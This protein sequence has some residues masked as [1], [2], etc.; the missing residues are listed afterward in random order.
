[1]RLIDLDPLFVQHSPRVEP[2]TIRGAEGVDREEV[3]EVLYR[4]PVEKLADAHGIYFDCPKCVGERGHRVLCWFE[5]R[6]PDGL[7]PGPGRW[8]PE[9]SGFADLSFVPGKKSNSVQLRGG[10]HW[11]GFITRGEVSIIP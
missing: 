3:G 7:E 1:M 5:G 10:C 4:V 11:H 9:G 6:V 2:R 8:K